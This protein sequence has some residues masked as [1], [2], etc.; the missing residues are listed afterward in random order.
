M[1]TVINPTGIAAPA[2]SYHHAVLSADVSSLLTVSGQLGEY[3]DGRCAEGAAEQAKLAWQ[4]VYEVLRAANM[5]V[6]D[7]VKVTSYIVG[8]EN[9]DAYAEAHQNALGDATPPWT[10]VVVAALGKPE[11]LIE[12][13]VMAAVSAGLSQPGP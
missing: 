12:V 10:L 13:D 1:K 5:S 6:G 9:I 2:S 3:P 4:N 8:S 7:I 11:Y